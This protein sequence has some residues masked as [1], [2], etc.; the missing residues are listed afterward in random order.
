MTYGI[1]VTAGNNI[2]QV[3]SENA[4]IY[5]VGNTGTINHEDSFI[6]A[7]ASD[8]VFLRF[9]SSGRANNSRVV[10]NLTNWNSTYGTYGG[11]KVRGYSNP[12]GAFFATYG[13][14]LGVSSSDHDGFNA[15]GYDYAVY[16][17]NP[18]GPLVGNYG[19]QIRDPNN[20]VKFDTRR[21]QSFA[22]YIKKFWIPGTVPTFWGGGADSA[23]GYE[24]KICGLDEWISAN[25]MIDYI[26]GDADGWKVAHWIEVAKNYTGHGYTGSR[27]GYY[28][29]CWAGGDFG[30]RIFNAAPMPF[31]RLLLQA[32][33][34]T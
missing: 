18:Q 19:L 33:I 24:S 34:P 1:R 29:G 23:P 11:Y 30:F 32:D 5:G 8:L 16:T 17:N 14:G 28:A 27:T 12:K 3:D 4:D 10:Y 22:L 31:W 9:P 20:S 7:T 26:T 13:S 25:W 2:L 21:F 6:P 15:T